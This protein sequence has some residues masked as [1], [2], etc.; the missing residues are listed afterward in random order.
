MTRFKELRRID[1]AVKH[2]NKAELEWA[3]AYCKMRLQLASRKDHT[4]YWRGLE[5]RVLEALKDS[6]E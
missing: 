5:A 3:L 4:K 6:A 1:S 2:K